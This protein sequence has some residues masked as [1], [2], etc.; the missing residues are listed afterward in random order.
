[1]KRPRYLSNFAP[2]Y[3]MASVASLN[4][5]LYTLGQKILVIFKINTGTTLNLKPL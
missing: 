4:P 3:G 1:M 2:V 5:I